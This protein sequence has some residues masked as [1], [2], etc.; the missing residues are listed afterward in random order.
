MDCES[1]AEIGL[2]DWLPAIDP[3]VGTRGEGDGFGTSLDSWMPFFLGCRPWDRFGMD[4]ATKLGLSASPRSGAQSLVRPYS[5]SIASARSK[6]GPMHN[7]H[8]LP[9]RAGSAFALLLMAGT[10]PGPTSFPGATTG[11]PAPPRS[12]PTAAVPATSPLRMSRARPP[13]V[14]QTPSS[15]IYVP[16]APRARA[17]PTSS[18][19]PGTPSFCNWRTPPRRQPAA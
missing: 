8:S 2:I 16:S 14:R 1:I 11:N 4:A 13:R 17:V 12:A 7:K 5:V 6:E 9:A 18:T 3:F 10:R 15:P 19:M